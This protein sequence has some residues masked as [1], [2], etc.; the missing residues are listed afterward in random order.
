M[1][2]VQDQILIDLDS[3]GQSLNHTSNL[4]WMRLDWKKFNSDLIQK[5]FLK[6]IDSIR[7]VKFSIR[8]K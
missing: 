5:F 7:L 4:M 3:D 2:F 6:K 1:I 8:L